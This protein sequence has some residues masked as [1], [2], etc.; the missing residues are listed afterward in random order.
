MRWQDDDRLGVSCELE[1][2]EKVFA[3]CYGFKTTEWL[4]PTSN[5]LMDI[6][7]KVIALVNSP[8]FENKLLIIY[9]AGHA[10]MNEARQQIWLRYVS[11][12]ASRLSVTD[13]Q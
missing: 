12:H 13:M 11:Y 7:A 6:M 10:A 3:R 5:P 9:Y 8:G 2:L 1:D 4:I